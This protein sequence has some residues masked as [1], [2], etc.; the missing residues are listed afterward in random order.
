MA[1]HLGKMK[2][3]FCIHEFFYECLLCL[4]VVRYDKGSNYIIQVIDQ[5]T[6]I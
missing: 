2:E 4:N 3:Q 1:I 5:S 6:Y